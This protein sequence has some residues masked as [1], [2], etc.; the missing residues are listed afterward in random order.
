MN[1]IKTATAVSQYFKCVG[2]VRTAK[3]V[4]L[5]SVIRVANY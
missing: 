1:M 4:G 3:K 2:V 5:I